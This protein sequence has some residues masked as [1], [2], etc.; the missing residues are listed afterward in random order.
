MSISPY[1]YYFYNKFEKLYDKAM[2]WNIKQF[3]YPFKSDERL[4]CNLKSKIIMKKAMEYLK[5]AKYFL[6]RSE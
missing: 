3:N 4:L 6:E 5:K 1:F 2:D